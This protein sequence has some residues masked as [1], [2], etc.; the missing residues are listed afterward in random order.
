MP[1]PNFA[2]LDYYA[3]LKL[4]DAFGEDFETAVVNVVNTYLSII[5]QAGDR[6]ADF[7]TALP[8]AD[9]EGGYEDAFI[10]V[11]L[12]RQTRSALQVLLKDDGI[13]RDMIKT[14]DAT[15]PEF[16]EEVRRASILFDLEHH[17]KHNSAFARDAREYDVGKPTKSDIED[18]A[19]D[20]GSRALLDAHVEA[21]QDRKHSSAE[22][23]LYDENAE[24]GVHSEQTSPD[25]S[26]ATGADA[27]RT[28]VQENPTDA[29]KSSELN[30]LASSDAQMVP[31][32]PDNSAIPARGVIRD[33]AIHLFGERPVRITVQA[34][35][36][37][38]KK[39][40]ETFRGSTT[41]L[42][43]HII[44]VA[45]GSRKADSF[46]RIAPLISSEISIQYAI[47]VPELKKL[48]TDIRSLVRRLRPPHDDTGDNMSVLLDAGYDPNDPRTFIDAFRKLAGQ[49][50]NDS[51]RPSYADS[52]RGD[53]GWKEGDG[54]AW[55][56]D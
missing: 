31:T 44:K 27:S 26:Q 35:N 47:S 34:E 50:K 39:P 12:L 4:R 5:Q 8:Y 45:S 29:S 37:S 51:N 56:N 15:T 13:M 48:V 52:A 30:Q 6:A 22:I 46:P 24:R 42:A 25:V 20:G 49:G 17:S 18:S 32:T 19:A 7:I 40:N 14:P 21:A 36:Y 1:S 54:D 41:W 43:D 11:R 33:P 3:D 38:G 2:A 53:G 10:G 16:D 9:P 28:P 55:N 23:R